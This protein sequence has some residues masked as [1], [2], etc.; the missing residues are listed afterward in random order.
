MS[1]ALESFNSKNFS[2]FSALLVSCHFKPPSRTSGFPE[3]DEPLK[4][5]KTVAVT[6]QIAHRLNNR[7]HL[8]K[9]MHR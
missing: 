2:N 8:E 6:F 4:F 7:Y 1:L 5:H 9:P 3:L